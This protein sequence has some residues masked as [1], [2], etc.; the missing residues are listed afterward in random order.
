MSSSEESEHLDD[1]D[2]L[3]GYVYSFTPR[4]AR[5]LRVAFRPARNANE[6]IPHI[7]ANNR[8]ICDNVSPNKLNISTYIFSQHS[9]GIR[10]P[11]CQPCFTPWKHKY[12][13]IESK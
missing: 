11:K 7:M 9:A 13:P 10:S 12:Y 2:F 3:S 6:V 5:S 8:G 4:D 1:P